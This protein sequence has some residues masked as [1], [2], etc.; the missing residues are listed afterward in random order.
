MHRKRIIILGSTG[1]IGQSAIAVMRKQ[2]K[3]LKIVALSAHT[4]EEMLVEQAQEFDVETVALSG[5]EPD[6]EEITHTGPEGLLK[7]IEETE[8]DLVLNGI[9][10]SSGL[11]PSI[12]ALTSGKD[13]AL[14]NKETIVMAGPLIKK[15]A[16]DNKRVIIPVDSEHSAIFHLMRKVEKEDLA[17]IILTASGGA[18]RDA[19]LEE[20]QYVTVK[21]AL[22]HP[23][24]S[25]GVKI[26]IDCA[27]MANKGLELIETN[28]L[29]DIPPEKIKVVVHPQSYVHSLIRT[30]EGS[31]YAQISRPDMRIP[32]QN[33]FTYPDLYESYMKH[34]DLMGKTLEFHEP[35]M[36][37]YPMLEIAFRALEQKGSYP[38]AYNAANEV[39]VEAFVKGRIAFLDVPKV[40]DSILQN[41][42]SRSPES[43]E[44]VQDIHK[45]VIREAGSTLKQYQG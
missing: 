21:Q 37:K 45:R 33:A 27:T 32:I 36:K 44:E 9:S 24:W 11:L 29:F 10:G 2:I 14:A 16:A 43:I 6:S 34:F 22:V 18:F 12:A 41:G 8:A 3:D 13:L 30:T 28:Y 5:R 7:M 35:D 31:L 39:A 17:E 20:L 15:I 25:M 23:T 42:W 38:L 26:T 40:V 1:S 4:N 19:G